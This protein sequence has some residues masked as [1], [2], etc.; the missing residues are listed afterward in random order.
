MLGLL[1][2]RC[3]QTR[4]AAVSSSRRSVDCQAFLPSASSAPGRRERVVDHQASVHAKRV[5]QHRDALFGGGSKR[6]PEVHKLR[7]RREIASV[8]IT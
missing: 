8:V 2:G 7:G 5:V 3:A 1:R 4:C 6:L